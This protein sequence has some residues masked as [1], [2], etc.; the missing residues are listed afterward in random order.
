MSHNLE[1]IRLTTPRL[2]I[3]PLK[4]NQIRTFLE[5]PAALEIELGYPISRDIL[6]TNVRRALRIKLIRMV[7]TPVE[8]HL[9][10]TYWLIKIKAETF[11]AGLIGFKGVPDQNGW[12]EI[13]YGI[14]PAYW[15]QGYMTEAAGVMVKWAL[16][17][18][19]CTKVTAN[20][21]KNPASYRVL[22]KIGF[23]LVSENENGTTWHKP[24]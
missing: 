17:Q 18:P 10:L 16:T 13:G 7:D 3:F 19:E 12:T 20:E 14:D 11:G 21:T 24:A 1:I 6:D 2:E 5:H 8:N 23:T 9:W 15:N 22:Q 4:E